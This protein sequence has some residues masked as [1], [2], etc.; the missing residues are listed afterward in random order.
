MARSVSTPSNATQEQM[1]YDAEHTASVV[2]QDFLF[3][4]EHG[5]TREDL[6]RNIERRPGLWGR[7]ENWLSKLPSSEVSHVAQP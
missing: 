2:N 1:F 7:F 3:L 6:A 5:L 4:V